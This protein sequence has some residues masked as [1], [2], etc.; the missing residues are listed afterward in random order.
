MGSRDECKCRGEKADTNI[1]VLFKSHIATIE[2]LHWARMMMMMIKHARIGY[3]HEK[4]DPDPSHVPDQNHGSIKSRY[5]P[6]RSVGSMMGT[7]FGWIRYRVSTCSERSK[8]QA[9]ALGKPSLDTEN[10]YLRLQS[11]PARQI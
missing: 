2:C 8:S 6:Y 4:Q 5:R 10:K 1:Y 9:L 3:R 11:S 7:H